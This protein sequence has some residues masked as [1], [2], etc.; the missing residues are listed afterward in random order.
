MQNK[1][2]IYSIQHTGSHFV[3]N[4]VK[5]AAKPNKI[6]HTGERLKE[7]NP[8]SRE[9]YT[10]EEWI[11]KGHDQNPKDKM[12]KADLIIFG[13]HHMTPNSTLVNSM[14]TTK[15]SIPILIPIRD[16]ILTANTSIFWHNKFNSKE[17]W[18]EKHIIRIMKLFTEI[19]SI[20][21]ESCFYLPV[22]LYNT[23]STENKT[24]Q[25]N[26]LF[27]FCNLDITKD[28]KNFITEL[29]PV[30]ETNK[31]S[32]AKRIIE[33]EK[34]KT[35]ILNNDINTIEKTMKV[36]LSY[37]YR[38]NELKQRLRDVGYHNLIWY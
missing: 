34:N 12:S 17:E 32:K 10:L 29:G 21:K 36:E 24:I 4:L 19:L 6:L 27:E 31:I 5:T 16:P 15:S 22:D 30:H 14:I 3:L 2:F 28:T 38:N 25:I 1:V 8:I 35:A 13:C 37:L 18:R 33:F 9:Y 7:T 26:K 11:Q 20:H 23:L